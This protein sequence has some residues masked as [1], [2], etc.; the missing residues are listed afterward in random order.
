[1]ESLR[2]SFF[3]WLNAITLINEELLYI[4]IYLHCLVIINCL[5][6]TLFHFHFHFFFHS[7]SI[8]ENC[9][10]AFSHWIFFK[11]NIE[12]KKKEKTGKP[13]EKSEKNDCVAEM[14]CFLSYLKVLKIVKII[15]VLFV[16]L[17]IFPL[18]HSLTLAHTHIY[19]QKWKHSVCQLKAS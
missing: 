5:W 13:S 15:H 8:F 18:T 6:S 10:S 9:L 17:F 2:I 11:G 14:E 16:F 1:M 7:S 19:I 12:Q 3:F 4:Y